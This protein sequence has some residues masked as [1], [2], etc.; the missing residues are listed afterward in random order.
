[1]L[2]TMLILTVLLLVTSHTSAQS[3]SEE[4]IRAD[5]DAEFYENMAECSLGVKAVTDFNNKK[6]FWRLCDLDNGNRIISI[7]SH[8]D[9]S[10]F[11]EVYFEKNRSLV[12]AIET[13]NYIPKNHFIQKIWNVEFYIAN[14]KLVALMSLGHGKTE[15]EDWDPNIIF[16]MYKV[17]LNELSK[18]KQ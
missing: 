17:R 9:S 14:K 5:T 13:Q 7:E 3:Q 2:R 4:E 11:Q 8:N 1:M 18:I 12:Y 15:T 10:Y 6:E 16:D